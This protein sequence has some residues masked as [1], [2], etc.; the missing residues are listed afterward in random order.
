MRQLSVISA[1][2]TEITMP[3]KC[4][5]NGRF[6]FTCAL[7]FNCEYRAKEGYR[8]EDRPIYG[9]QTELVHVRTA[10][11][12]GHELDFNSHLREL[13]VD[14]GINSLMVTSHRPQERK[15]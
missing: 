2:I 15:L 12:M 7:S 5:D 14:M 4:K 9:G 8:D 13:T 6:Q 11:F 3:P 1:C 10:L